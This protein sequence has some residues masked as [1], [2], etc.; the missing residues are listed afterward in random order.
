MVRRNGNTLPFAEIPREITR[1]V[2]PVELKGFYSVI[3]PRPKKITFDSISDG[4]EFRMEN[5]RYNR[6]YRADRSIDSTTFDGRT[7]RR[8]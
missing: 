1:S 7:A 2:V 6:V 3:S 4:G 8:L 5:D